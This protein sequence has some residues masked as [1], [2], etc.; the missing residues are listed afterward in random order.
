MKKS[1]IVIIVIVALL[2]VLCIYRIG[3]FVAGKVSPDKEDEK[4]TSVRVAT[5]EY[6]DIG[7]ATPMSGRIT[8]AKEAAIIPMASGQVTKVNVKVGDYVKA[9]TVL[10]EIDKGAVAG[11]VSQAKA[12]YD[13]ARNTYNNMEKLYAE[14]AISKQDYDSARVSYISAREN[15]NMAAEQY[16]NFSPTSPIDGYV[17]SLN[18]SVGNMAAAGNM[19]ASVANTDELE[20]STTASEYIAGLLSVGDSVEV[21]VDGKDKTYTG[22]V[23]TLSPAPAYGTFTYPVTIKL[24]NTSGE[25]MSGQF[26]EIRVNAEESKNALCVP[27]DAVVMKNGVTVLITVNDEGIA[28]FAPVESG[29][30]NGE[31]VEIKSGVKEGDRI[32]ISGQSFVEDGEK[33][34]VVE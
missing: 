16:S 18:V 10:F 13:L 11:T 15:Y 5:V 3:S 7:K 14:G 31:I 8:A 9:G 32:I 6:M 28:T 33:V 27:S 17:T 12:A 4:L 29:I 21:Y 20:I 19:A 23:D 34:K 22:V 30:D 25:L 26:A 2:A 24:D 1:K